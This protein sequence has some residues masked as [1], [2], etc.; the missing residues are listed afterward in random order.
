MSTSF[1]ALY[2][3]QLFCLA[4]TF[5]P[6]ALWADR[7]YLNNP[8]VPATQSEGYYCEKLGGDQYQ[9]LTEI[10]LKDFAIDW[11]STTDEHGPLFE[12]QS[13]WQIE[14][15]FAIKNFDQIQRFNLSSAPKSIRDAFAKLKL[16]FGSYILLDVIPTTSNHSNSRTSTKP[17]V[18]KLK[19]LLRP[20]I[21]S[22]SFSSSYSISN[23]WQQM[24][25]APSIPNAC[26][27]TKKTHYLSAD[28]TKE[29]FSTGFQLTNLTICNLNFGNLEE[30]DHSFALNCTWQERK[31]LPRCER[32]LQIT[33]QLE[34]INQAAKQINDA[35]DIIDRQETDEIPSYPVY[36]MQVL[37]NLNAEHPIYFEL[38]DRF[39]TSI[40]NRMKSFL[41]NNNKNTVINLLHQ[42]KAV[43]KTSPVI[44]RTEQLL[45]SRGVCYFVFEKKCKTIIHGTKTQMLP[46]DCPAEGGLALDHI[47]TPTTVT[48]NV[49]ELRMNKSVYDL[50]LEFHR[51]FRADSLEIC[52]KDSAWKNKT[53]LRLFTSEES[54]NKRI[55]TDRNPKFSECIEYRARYAVDTRDNPFCEN[56]K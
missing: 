32:D 45:L 7:A 43:W 23:E 24:F 14:E 8:K 20:S 42:A 26:S 36:N 50:G 11:Q 35:L 31:L 2:L 37:A 38:R 17:V 54:L 30:V 25:L 21:G 1:K 29:I 56:E 52:S 6:V 40:E 48:S 15:E 51:G 27:P 10:C 22:S 9:Y 33:L 19:L 16:G 28:K 18:A 53:Y 47:S 34:R 44:E 49:P 41:A 5:F 13:R 46:F 39:M 55:E 3:S 12:I 4:L